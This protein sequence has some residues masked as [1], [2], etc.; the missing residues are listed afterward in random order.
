MTEALEKS[1]SRWRELANA[2]SLKEV[3]LGRNA[4]AL[5]EAHPKC[6]GCPVAKDGHRD[7]RGTPYDKAKHAFILD[8]A[9]AFRK[10]ALEEVSY[11]E[12]L[13][14]PRSKLALASVDTTSEPTDHTL[15][16]AASA[17]DFDKTDAQL[18]F[19]GVVAGRNDLDL[20]SRQYAMRDRILKLSVEVWRLREKLRELGVDVKY[21][22]GSSCV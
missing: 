5:C 11:L 4:C 7:C 15:Q 18:A 20:V 12:S 6:S 14:P 13:R 8:Y 16:T 1:I 19:W 22:G 2:P 9:S 21:E 10:A 17:G 3:V